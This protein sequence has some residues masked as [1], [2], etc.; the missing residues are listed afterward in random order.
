MAAAAD[1]LEGERLHARPGPRR[2]RRDGDRLGREPRQAAAGRHPHARSASVFDSCTRP[3]SATSSARASSARATGSEIYISH[4]GMVEVYTGQ[5]KDSTV[6]Q[7]RPADPQL[8]AEILA[9]LMVKLGAK[10]EQ[11]RATRRRGR[12]RAGAP[13]RARLVDG[14]RAHAA[15]RRR[16]RPRLAPGRPR[17]RPQRLHGR[18]P[19]PRPGPVLRSLRRSGSTPASEEP[20]FFSSMFSFGKKTED[21]AALAK[22]RVTVKA[23]GDDDARSSVLD[24]QGAPEN[25]EAGQR[26]VTL[27][28]EDLIVTA[29]PVARSRRALRAPCPL[30]QPGQRQHRQRHAGRGERA[31]SDTR[32]LVDCG[33]SLRELEMRLARAGLAPERP[34]RDLR[35][36]RARRSH[37]LRGR[38]GAAPR[39]AGLDE[40]RHLARGRRAASCRPPAASRATASD[41]DRRRSS[42]S[43]S[44]CPRCRAS[45]CSC[46]AATA[47]RSLGVLTDLGS[48]TAHMLEQPARLRRAAARVQPRR[49]RCCRPRAI[50]RR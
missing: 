2:G 27:L 38:A 3:A 48:I 37:R 33:F 14:S 34:R 41:R 29:A 49:A 36:P 4:R 24:A 20:G 11:A 1:V 28:V 25:G 23:E 39:H 6:W 19:R 42:C 22:Y 17:A 16:L 45:R 26:I 12:P 30:L 7:P 5:R 35:H 44:P 47:P 9:R 18:R 15:G 10:E 50:R 43:P 31:A 40:P 8:E 13:A 21:T 46:A 32:L